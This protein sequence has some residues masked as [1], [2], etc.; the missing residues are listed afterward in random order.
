M[1]LGVNGQPG[2]RATHVQLITLTCIENVPCKREESILQ[3][4]RLT[5]RINRFQ[6]HE[7][8]EPECWSLFAVAHPHQ[9]DLEAR[10]APRSLYSQSQT[11]LAIK[12]Y[13]CRRVNTCP[14]SIPL[15]LSAHHGRRRASQSPRPGNVSQYPLDTICQ[16]DIIENAREGARTGTYVVER[17]RVGGRAW[18]RSRRCGQSFVVVVVVAAARRAEAPHTRPRGRA[19]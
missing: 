11:N 12:S 7:K 15:R 3:R 9:G 6:T 13:H 19:L 17:Q 4:V 2:P 16:S 14:S 18:H 5:K 10:S 1:E 8:V